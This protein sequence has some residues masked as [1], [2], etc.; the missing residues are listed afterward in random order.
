MARVPEDEI[1][2]IKSGI[3]VAR[4]AEAAGVQ[5]RQQGQGLTGRCPFHDD[6]TPSLVITPASNLWHCL[7]ACQAGG[8]VI[9]WVMRAHG[10]SFRH[11]VE[12]LRADAPALS[13]PPQN[14][15]RT[16]TVK[17]QP[18]PAAEDAALLAD[19]VGFY[20]DALAGAAAFLARRK[21]ADPEAAEC[22]RLGF[23][24]RTLGYR[25]PHSRTAA[26]AA[27][28]SSLKR[29]G[30]LRASGHEHFRGC[31]VIPVTD[32]HGRIG[33]VYG[34]RIDDHLKAGVPRHLYLPGPHCGVWNPAAFSSPEL[35]VCES[36]IDSLTLWCA[37]FRHVTASYGTSGWTADHT[38][39][40]REH[41]VSRVLIAYDGD[42]AGDAGAQSLAA[43]LEPLGIDCLRIPLP[44]G[45]DINDVAVSSRVPREALGLLLR[46]AAPCQS[47][48][49][50]PAPR[51][52]R[53]PS[54]RRGRAGD[55]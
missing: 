19:V 4:L 38:R 8:S 32:E 9:D 44:A 50:R 5:L 41:Q 25:L 48:S 7:G 42:P 53:E 10:V 30:V 18:L 1:N 33:E 39:L 20:H 31:L 49:V 14:P 40:V 12:L 2:R 24:D 21:I 35:I 13:S 54:A 11:A 51:R 27:V 15:A 46:H 16:R 23:C 3:S 43:E 37:G 55:T 45:A 34:R 17:L 52:I 22:F 28:R 26:G 6:F 29:L 36:L 47:A